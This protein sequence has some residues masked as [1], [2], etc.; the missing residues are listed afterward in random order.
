MN[1]LSFLFFRK[2]IAVLKLFKFYIVALKKVNLYLKKIV[3]WTAR[4]GAQRIH[5]GA[6]A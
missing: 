4:R 3:P 2:L 5:G 6:Q 1:I